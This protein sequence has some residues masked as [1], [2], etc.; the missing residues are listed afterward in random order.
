MNQQAISEN[1]IDTIKPS[2]FRKLVRHRKWS[3]V[4]T[5]ACKGYAQT[6]L[7]ILPKSHA[8]EFLLFCNRNPGPCPVIEVTDPGEYHPKFS[9]PGADLRTD[10]SKYRVFKDGEIIDEPVDITQYWQEDLVAF[11]LGCSTNFEAS[12]Q[13]ANISYR[14]IGDNTTSIECVPAGGFHGNMVVSTRLFNSSHD[15][16]RAIQ[17]TSRNLAA[18]GPPVYIGR[19]PGDIGI[20]DIY[21]PDSFSPPKKIQS[22]KPN[23]II[24]CWAC[25]VTPQAVALSSKIPFMISHCPGYMF[26]TDILSEELT[27]M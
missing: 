23:D 10:L 5:T 17:I 15:A 24:M 20:K 9:A 22:I 21:H 3:A 12:L 2:E 25:G 19:S 16:V 18:H 1:H 14:Y 26:V 27:V 8:F 6:N 7:V 13:S 11:L 4:T